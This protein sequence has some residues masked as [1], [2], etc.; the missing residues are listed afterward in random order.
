VGRIGLLVLLALAAA[1]CGGAPAPVFPTA[2]GTCGPPQVV[3]SRPGES[4]PP[5]AA[6]IWVLDGA[7]SRIDAA[8]YSLTNPA[9]PPAKGRARYGATALIRARE[10]S[11][12]VRLITDAGQSRNPA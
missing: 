9:P 3:F 10:R 7:R 2:A 8:V 11:L 12:P 4:R 6:L 5:S 1:A